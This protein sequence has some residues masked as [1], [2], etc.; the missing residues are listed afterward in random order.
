[1][2]SE[3]ALVRGI[4]LFHG[5]IEE[6]LTL[7]NGEVS[8]T[9]I[10]EALQMVGVLEDIYSLPEGLQTTLQGQPEPLSRG[11]AARLVIARAILMDPRLIIIDGMLDG[12][13]EST[14]AG[15]LAELTGPKA[16]WSL[17]VLTHERSVAQHF[18]KSHQL[19]HG[20]LVPL[21]D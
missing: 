15:L 1:L 10:R 4:E 6:N 19:Q 14:V 9:R 20:K 12:I 2:R 5:T 11:Q 7:T 18:S 3:I 13:D 16:R 21:A 8:S 17:L